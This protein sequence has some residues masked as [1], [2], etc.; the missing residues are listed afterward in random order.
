MD[1]INEILK[2]ISIDSLID[3]LSWS[4]LFYGLFLLITSSIGML[5]MPDLYTKIHAASLA[6]SLAI[7]I[8]MISLAIKY[9]ANLNGAKVI[10]L[11]IIMLIIS[12][13]SSYSIAGSALYCSIVPKGN[14]K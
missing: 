7:P 2:Q 9:G 8:I 11:M 4:L 14:R 5:R 10:L 6:E 12:P 13:L 3:I 1:I